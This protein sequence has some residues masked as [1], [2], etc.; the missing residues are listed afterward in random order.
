M[1]F[2]GF[3]LISPENGFGGYKEVESQDPCRR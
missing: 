1:R 2:L 3:L